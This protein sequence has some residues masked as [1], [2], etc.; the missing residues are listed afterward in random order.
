MSNL[1]HA[2]STLTLMDVLY[3][4]EST[5]STAFLVQRQNPTIENSYWQKETENYKF[6]KL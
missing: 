5:Q 4:A 6:F 3:P 2:S 1:P